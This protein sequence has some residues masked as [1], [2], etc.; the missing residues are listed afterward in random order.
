MFAPLS[1]MVTDTTDRGR[2]Q[3]G[4]CFS[5]PVHVY[6]TLPRI[7]P[8]KSYWPLRGLCLTDTP[9]PQLNHDAWLDRL[10]HTI[11]RPQ[12]TSPS[13]L[14]VLTTGTRMPAPLGT[15]PPTQPLLDNDL[16]YSGLEDASRVR[17]TSA[18]VLVDTTLPA[19][20]PLSTPSPLPNTY[21]DQ[22]PWVVP[23][24]LEAPI[25]SRPAAGTCAMLPNRVLRHELESIR[26]KCLTQKKK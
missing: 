5:N 2:I 12:G 20:T 21:V 18:Q 10:V 1:V 24:V 16:P 25:H 11:T 19:H 15:V 17:V 23:P 7:G 9:G 3:P 14:I 26:S 22:R 6:H 4:H 13:N 8:E